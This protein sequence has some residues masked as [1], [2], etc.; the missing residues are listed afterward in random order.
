MAPSAS[1]IVELWSARKK[2]HQ[3]RLARMDELRRA[4]CGE[5]DLPLP[6]LNRNERPM[7]AN[8]IAQGLDQTAMRIVS[9]MPNVTCP[10]LRAG[11]DKWE[12][13]AEDRRNAIYSWWTMNDLA[14]I[15]A[16]RA[17]WLVGY[18]SAPVIIAPDLRRN[19]PS[20]EAC[21][22]RMVLPP[23]GD[24]LCPTDMIVTYRK[25]LGWLRRIYPQSVAALDVG[26][27]SSRSPD[28][29][30]TIVEYCDDE[31]MMSRVVI[32]RA[33]DQPADL[34]ATAGPSSG[35][36]YVELDRIGNKAGICPAVCPSRIG[37]DGPVGQFDGLV[38]LFWNQSM[39]M[40]LE[41]LAVKRSIFADEWI[42]GRPNEQVQI[43]SEADGL[44]GIRGEINGGTIQQLNLQPGVQTY[45]TMDRLER[46]MRL[47]GGI[48]AEMTGESANN[49][50]TARRGAQVMSSTVDFAIA[51][52][53]KIFEASLREENVRAIAIDKAYFSG[54]KAFYFSWNGQKGR[55]TYDP[56]TLWVSDENQ[57]S[58]SFPGAD[59][60]QL[61][62]GVGQRMGM[63]TMSHYRAMELDPLIEDPNLERDRIEGESLQRSFMQGLQAQVAQG[64]IPPADAA[65][66]IEKVVVGRLPLFEAVRQ[67][68]DEAQ[69]RQATSGPPGTP[70]A[71][72][73][74]GSPEAQPGLAQ[75]GMGAEAGISPPA[76]GQLNLQALMG[77]LRR[78]AIA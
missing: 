6:E 13:N 64:Q 25:S 20:W 46:A 27:A 71:A 9:T 32:G 55:G 31:L 78:T 38:G 76:Q 37:L 15:Q 65:A 54:P 2:A 53:Q 41:F 35:A 24:D 45:P 47:T 1:E 63:E 22:P 52:A 50:R 48:P 3:R 42:I 39:L 43:I 4:Y 7:V 67:V 8:L 36:P 70:E 72:T 23:P 58:Y 30:F 60:N 14:L 16:R 29:E 18:S 73:D 68:H 5:L 34:N 11:M 19:V 17:R 21:D 26:P 69:R 33:L 62:V 49:I 59:I 61:I 77:N 75:P 10:P 44:A 40:A 57:V 56:A 12:T 66:I 28:V 51:E 74:P